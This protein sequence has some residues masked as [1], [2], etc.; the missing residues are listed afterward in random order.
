MTQNVLSKKLYLEI[1]LKT[2]EWDIRCEHRVCRR[3]DNISLLAS[4]P[5]TA[6]NGSVFSLN[7][8]NEFIADKVITLL[9]Y[10]V[11]Q[12]VNIATDSSR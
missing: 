6:E 8:W 3:Y 11:S 9:N 7:N 12:I 2:D 5:T 10:T 1:R 4:D